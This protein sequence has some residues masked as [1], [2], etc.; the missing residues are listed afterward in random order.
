M[1]MKKNLVVV[2]AGDNSLHE[3]M[4]NVPY[5]ERSYD[6]LLSFFSEGAYSNFKPQPGVHAVFF[7]GGKW[8]G[9]YKTLSKK[10]IEVYDFF[11]L[12]DD[13][14]LCNA[15]D[16]NLI[17]E[18]TKRFGLAVS[19]PSL[20]HNSYFSHFIFFQCKGFRVRYSNFIEVMVPCLRKDLL[21][22]VLPFFRD[23]MSGFGLDYIWCRMPE[24]G[25]FTSGILDHVSVYHTRPVGKVLA[26]SMAI[27]GKNPQEDL[28]QINKIF[29]IKEKV[30]PLVYAGI[31]NDGNIKYGK[32]KMSLYMIASWVKVI[33][34]FNCSTRPYLEMYRVISKSIRKPL[35]FT[36][37][38]P[39]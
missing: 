31:T 38:R 21:K 26:S 36:F 20:T 17:F 1:A 7:S 2:R 14:I 13:D 32:I 11:W 24:S 28:E 37:L 10:Y 3:N 15:A 25:P 18:M 5:N 9:I 22:R 27:L 23:S 19:Q 4:L 30:Y 12:P 29:N 33:N 35:K 34:A 8:D 39:L 6:V 16:I